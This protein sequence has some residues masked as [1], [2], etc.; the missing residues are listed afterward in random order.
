MKKNKIMKIAALSSLLLG[1]GAALTAAALT[2]ITTKENT[3]SDSVH[4]TEGE[5]LAFPAKRLAAEEVDSVHSVLGVQYLT[6]ETGT[7]SLRFVAALD[8]YQGLKSA[9]FTR[10]IKD[11]EGTTL[12]TNTL[13]VDTVYTSLVDADNVLWSTE[14]PTGYNY[15]MVYTMHNIPSDMKDAVLEVTF[16]T[17][18]VTGDPITRS[19]AGNVLGVMGIPNPELG[20]SGGLANTLEDSNIDCS[21]YDGYYIAPTYI[22]AGTEEIIFPERYVE[23]E[24]YVGKDL[25]PITV[26]GEERPNYGAFE[27]I[28]GDKQGVRK[29]VLPDTIKAFDS[30]CY[31]G[32]TGLREIN[33]PRD[34]DQIGGNCFS[35]LELDTLYYDAIN[36]TDENVHSAI[37]NPVGEVVVSHEVESLPNSLFGYSTEIS[38]ITYEGTEAEWAV[39]AENAT[40]WVKETTDVICSDTEIVTVT[41]DLGDGKLGESEGT[42]TRS[43]IVGKTAPNLGNPTPNDSG[44]I[45]DGW[46]TEAEGG[47][48]YTFTEPVMENI[49]LYARYID[50]PAG[51]SMDNPVM[52]TEATEGT[53]ETLEALQ[54]YYIEFTAPTEDYWY[55]D[56][57]NVVPNNPNSYLDPVITI[58]DETGTEI[59]GTDSS[60]DNFSSSRVT[61]FEDSMLRIHLDA[62]ETIIYRVCV[63]KPYSNTDPSYDWGTFSYG[64]F[65]VE[66]DTL[67]DLG[68]ELT[69]DGPEVTLS[70]YRPDDRDQRIPHVLT[71]TAL[72]T[73]TVSLNVDTE[74]T[75]GWEAVVYEENEAGEMDEVVTLHSGRPFVVFDAV[76]GKTYY[77]EVSAIWDDTFETSE[78]TLTISLSGPQQ[79]TA[80]SNP[81]PYTLG[82]E[83][84]VEIPDGIDAHYYST[85][86]AGG[87]Y[88][89]TLSG[90]STSYAKIATIYNQAGEMIK[91]IREVGESDWWGSS[92]YGSDV[93]EEIALE[94]GTYIIKL[95]YSYNST[96]T[97]RF[98]MKELLPGDAFSCP[99]EVTWVDGSLTLTQGGQ[100]GGMYYSFTGFATGDY[101]LTPSNTDVTIRLYNANKEEISVIQTGKRISLVE[102]TTYY[103]VVEGEAESIT[104]TSAAYIGPLT[105]YAEYTGAYIGCSSSGSSY[106]RIDVT[107]NTLQWDNGTVYDVDR[108]SVTLNGDILHFTAN[109]GRIAVYTD[110]EKTI[111]FNNSSH[112]MMSKNSLIY[113][114]GPIDGEAL[115]TNNFTLNYDIETGEVTGEGAKIISVACQNPEDTTQVIGRDYVFILDGVIYFNVTVE[116]VD[117]EVTVTIDGGETYTYTREGITLVVPEA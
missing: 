103:L 97:F 52:I 58:F 86:V 32:M 92:T 64:I 16:T 88:A 5:T 81:L 55:F 71:Y 27:S 43:V 53:A 114:S 51:Y 31:S 110:G 9:S 56:L 7:N 107:V 94:A 90:G 26:V 68:E 2:P 3:P 59:E 85:T 49:T 20:W 91:E 117:G 111:V 15:Y 66:G 78:E 115:K 28:N 109:E 17:T 67:D 99:H 96:T 98:S 25:G 18:P 46:Y 38:K 104:I 93:Y 63:G 8:G 39:L 41:Y 112:Y 60:I 83:L 29:I 75:S 62:G 36:L 44:K 102:G 23:V 77:I 116:E 34:L 54:Y 48:K 19:V 13:A 84:E 108:D 24:G 22:P 30:Y 79:G 14:L 100:E 61:G 45:F 65:T 70:L 11:K 113:Q 21:T 42:L 72:D 47:E 106:Y 82:E 12:G 10:V 4:L 35:A 105:E 76:A 37:Q 89:I 80:M 101:E 73:Q 69:Y 57:Y 1:S 40:N 74:V 6:D 95:N 33:F 50:I 87:S